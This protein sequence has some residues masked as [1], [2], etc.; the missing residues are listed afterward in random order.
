MTFPKWL[1]GQHLA[2]H[3]PITHFTR[4]GNHVLRDSAQVPSW[5]AMIHD[6]ETH[7]IPWENIETWRTPRVE[8]EEPIPS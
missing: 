5:D 3:N 6:T 4:A 8:G 7:S 2:V 1:T